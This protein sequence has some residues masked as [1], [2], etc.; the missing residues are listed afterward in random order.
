MEML[1]GNEME[2]A[3]KKWQK[4]MAKI[5]KNRPMDQAIAIGDQNFSAPRIDRAQDLDAIRDGWWESWRI[6]RGRMN[7]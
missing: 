6:P 7:G 5:D 1:D 3:K 4:E 2:I